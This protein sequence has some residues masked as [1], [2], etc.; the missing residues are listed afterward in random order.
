MLAA[1]TNGCDGEAS[2]LSDDIGDSHMGSRGSEGSFAA[3][4]RGLGKQIHC[5][6][7]HQLAATAPLIAA[8]DA[9][10]WHGPRPRS[11]LFSLIGHACVPIR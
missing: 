4:E 10:V 2:R 7:K 9:D 8:A 6:R 11:A 1:S 5:R 3:V